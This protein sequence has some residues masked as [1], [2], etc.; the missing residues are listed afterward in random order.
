MSHASVF[1]DGNALGGDKKTG[2]IFCSKLKPIVSKWFSGCPGY[3]AL[4]LAFIVPQTNDNVEP[5]RSIGRNNFFSCCSSVKKEI[6]SLNK[7]NWNC[8]C[9]FFLLSVV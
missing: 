9:S 1:E 5:L 7:I 8:L 4:E 6:D 3:A 2:W